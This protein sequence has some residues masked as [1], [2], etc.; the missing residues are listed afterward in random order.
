MHSLFTTLSIVQI[1]IHT[2]SLPW[3]TILLHVTLMHIFKAV[4]KTASDIIRHVTAHPLA[5]G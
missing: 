3:G 5:R 1:G 2:A 4:S